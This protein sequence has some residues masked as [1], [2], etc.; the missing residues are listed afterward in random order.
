MAFDKPPQTLKENWLFY[1][2]DKDKDRPDLTM[3]EKWLLGMTFVHEKVSAFKGERKEVNM[4]NTKG[5]KTINIRIHRIWNIPLFKNM[6][7]NN[8]YVALRK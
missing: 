2:D 8:R 6:N 1:V 3:F 5:D 4:R 7:F